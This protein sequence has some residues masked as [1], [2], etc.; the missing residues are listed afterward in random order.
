MFRKMIAALGVLAMLAGLAGTAM[1]QET[2]KVWKNDGKRYWRVEEAV[3]PFAM[4]Q[5]QM[6][7]VPEK[8]EAAFL[9]FKYEGK[10]LNQAYFIEAPFAAPAAKGHECSWRMVYEQ[11]AMGKY[12]FCLENGVE[13]PCP[14]MN[15]AGECFGKK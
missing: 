12:H 5:T 4:P 9:G 11:K 10:H 3:K 13:K 15:A 2:Q 8:Q 7:A 14:G 6:L 1:A